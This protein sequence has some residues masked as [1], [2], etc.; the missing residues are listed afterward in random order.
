MNAVIQFYWWGFN[1]M[2]FIDF[3]MNW[4]DSVVASFMS[5]K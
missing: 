5:E 4:F 3:G 1:F 2:F